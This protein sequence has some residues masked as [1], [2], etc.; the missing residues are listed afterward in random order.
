MDNNEDINQINDEETLYDEMDLP[1]EVSTE[2]Y[3][4]EGTYQASSN[5]VNRNQKNIEANKKVSKMA[6][7]AAG[8]YF[9]G[10][11][12]G[13]VV[14]AINN[15]KIGDRLNE[16]IGRRMN[17]ISKRTFAGRAAQNAVNKL[18]ENGTLDKGQDAMNAM[19]G[20]KNGKTQINNKTN[21]SD[22]KQK[23]NFTMNPKK[24][25]IDTSKDKKNEI[26]RKKIVQFIIKHP[27][28]LGIILILFLL[29][30]I[31]LVI[32]GGGG[33]SSEEENNSSRSISNAC[34]DFPLN[35]TSL[36]KSEFVSLVQENIARYNRAPNEFKN[37]KDLETIYN[38]ATKNNCNPELV[39]ARAIQEGFTGGKYNYWGI[40]VYN[41]DTI[42]NGYSSLSE[43]VIAFCNIVNRYSTFYDLNHAYSYIG[44]YWANKGSNS[45]GGCTFID[46]TYEYYDNKSRADQVKSVCA[47]NECPLAGKSP[48]NPS[49]CLKTND[50]DQDA[51]TK[52]QN[53][54]L[55]NHRKNVF[56]LEPEQCLNPDSDFGNFDRCTI[57]NQYDPRWVDRNLGLSSTK[58]DWG[59]AVTSVSIGISCFGDNYDSIFNPAK[60]LD[61]A[62]TSKYVNSCFTGANIYW[63]CPAIQQFASNINYVNGIVDVLGP[64][65][66]YKLNFINSFDP[67]KHFF[68]VQIKN[69]KTSTHFVVLK[70]INKEKGTF[71]CLNPSGGIIT[72]EKL[73]DINAVRVFTK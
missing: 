6:T 73:K 69:E 24:S 55:S 14:N 11:I 53:W 41:G 28:I 21:P 58:M 5:R 19:S 27:W 4:D 34:S 52:Y 61:L 59:C 62:N 60:F 29:M 40:A 36:S 71:T 70:S 12:G 68:I 35:S 72:E 8:N 43:G 22:N 1:E 37:T 10:P 66:D 32:L 30:I 7:Q 15:T 25:T 13:K 18:D 57:F 17:D 2:N 39:V 44:D 31:M 63:T 48:E 64:N 46:Y 67:D 33:A 47:K 3:D 38:V 50:E 20:S 65:I 45:Y 49:K 54:A 23:M 56:G 51:Y 9:G 16:A 42:G 26:V